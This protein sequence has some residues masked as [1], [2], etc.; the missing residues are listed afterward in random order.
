MSGDDAK[1]LTSLKEWAKRAQQKSMLLLPAQWWPHNQMGTR[2]ITF[3]S[4]LDCATIY[5]FMLPCWHLW[6]M[7]TNQVSTGP[8][9]QQENQSRLRRF[10]CLEQIY[11]HRTR[12][13]IC[14]VLLLFFFQRKGHLSYSSELH[15]RRESFFGALKAGEQGIFS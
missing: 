13:L 9:A 5:E 1:P 12:N 8:R 10:T 11:L 15:P 6:P 14:Q 7:S 3:H 2:K 4:T